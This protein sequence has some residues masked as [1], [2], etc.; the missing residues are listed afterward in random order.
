MDGGGVGISLAILGRTEPGRVDLQQLIDPVHAVTF[1]RI[2]ADLQLFGIACRAA[3]AGEYLELVLSDGAGVI[4]TEYLLQLLI[5]RPEVALPELRR[6]GQSRSSIMVDGIRS[7]LSNAMLHAV[8]EIRD[9]KRLSSKP[10][11]TELLSQRIPAVVLEKLV[12]ARDAIDFE[13]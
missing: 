1:P 8:R 10:M 4:L 5:H 7:Y 6:H 12:V 3:Q 13:I 2:E 11:I 9:H